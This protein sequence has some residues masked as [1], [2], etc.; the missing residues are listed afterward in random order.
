MCFMHTKCILYI[1]VFNRVLDNIE[2]VL[3]T[4]NISYIYIYITEYIDN[5][6]CVSTYNVS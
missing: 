1:H 3:G 4:H 5:I 2:C 6:E